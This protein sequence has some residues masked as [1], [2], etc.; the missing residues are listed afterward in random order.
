M[1]R[2]LIIVALLV[3]LPSLIS[4]QEQHFAVSSDGEVSISGEDD[5]NI[6]QTKIAGHAGGDSHV[7]MVTDQ[8]NSRI[9]IMASTVEDTGPRL[10]LIGPEDSNT[11]A[12][13]YAIMAYGSNNFDLPTAKFIL[14]HRRVDSIQEMMRIEGRSRIIFPQ[15]NIGIG[16]EDPQYRLQVT[17]MGAFCDGTTWEDASSRE[18]KENIRELTTQEA[19]AALKNIK[20]VKFNYKQNPGD[21]LNLGFIAEDVPELVASKGRKSLSSMNVVAMLTKAVQQQQEVISSQQKAFAQQQEV[22][23]ALMERINKLEAR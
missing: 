22:I 19:M 5:R 18:L 13:G 12:R 15:G 2:L 17:P 23:D 11:V 10:H 14:R 3:A 16:A 6:F 9:T 8:T 1:K 7:Q 20:P 21:D 4:A